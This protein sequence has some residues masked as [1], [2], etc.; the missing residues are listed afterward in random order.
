[1]FYATFD[2]DIFSLQ[3]GLPALAS[4]LLAAGILAVA[5]K[6]M[7]AIEEDKYVG[8]GDCACAIVGSVPIR[9]GFVL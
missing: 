4:T 8:L 5:Y 7:G 2:L 3:Y 9:S 1:M 6:T